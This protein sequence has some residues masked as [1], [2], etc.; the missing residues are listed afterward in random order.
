MECLPTTTIKK[1][2]PAGGAI[3][4][5]PEST[6]PSNKPIYIFDVFSIQGVV[7]DVIKK[8]GD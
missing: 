2:V 6:N 7:T 8:G 5:E 4:L 3:R 1:I